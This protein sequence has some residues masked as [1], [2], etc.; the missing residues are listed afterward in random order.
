MHN[1]KKGIML[2]NTYKKSH[3]NSNHNMPYVREIEANKTY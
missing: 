2:W 1:G 3:V